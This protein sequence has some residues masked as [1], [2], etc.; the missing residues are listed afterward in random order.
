MN[1]AD[2]DAGYHDGYYDEPMRNYA[3]DSYYNGYQDGAE[4]A[5]EDA[6]WNDDDGLSDAEADAWTLASAGYG[7]EEDYGHFD[8]DY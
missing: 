1:R 7:T 5:H 4:T 3:S 2:Y 6:S 8:L